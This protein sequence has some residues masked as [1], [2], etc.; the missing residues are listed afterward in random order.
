M[1]IFAP[2]IIILNGLAKGVLK[3]LNVPLAHDTN[4][5]Y[6]AEEFNI[7]V[8][9]SYHQGVLNVT[10]KNIIQR[11]FK[12]ANLMAKQVMIPRPDMVCIPVDI[13][14]DDLKLL[15]YEN[16]YTRYPVYE[17]DID[18]IIG[19]VHIKDIFPIITENKKFS[20]HSIMR[21]PIFVPET[22]TIDNMLVEFKKKKSQMAIVIDEFGGTSGLITLEDVLEEVF[23]QVQDEFDLEEAEIRK[24]SENEYLIN[25]M[26]RIDEINEYF[27]L[28]I[29][30]EDVETIGGY[31]L[32]KLGRI[33]VIGDEVRIDN[34]A[35]IV[36]S[37]EG[38][39]I[40]KLMV[41]KL[42]T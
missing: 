4:L 17:N 16:Q 28:H 29:E 8:N 13:T 42:N 31:V 3:L 35:F 33:A 6:S 15:I 18:H 40:T 36:N 7:L 26:V 9:A 19:I 22:V 1:I 14:E 5:V 24:V 37:V 34:F 11:A 27:N 12:F 2:G 10:E 23:G 39:R 20:I 32:K 21:K 38:V 25:S 30:E 41:R